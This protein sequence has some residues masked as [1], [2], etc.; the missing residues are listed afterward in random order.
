MT[1]VESPNPSG[2]VPMLRCA[3][4]LVAACVALGGFAGS[5]FADRRGDDRGHGHPIHHDWHRRYYGGG[6]YPPPPVVYGAPYYPPPPVVYG[7]GFGINIHI[8]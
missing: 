8:R 5:A 7:P 6:Y 4:V 2:A 3:A 1:H